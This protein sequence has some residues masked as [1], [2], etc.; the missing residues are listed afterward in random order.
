MHT[1]SSLPESYLSHELRGS[2]RVG[3]FSFYYLCFCFS[4]ECTLGT[5]TA[6]ETVL[7]EY[8][9]ARTVRKRKNVKTLD[10]CVH[11]FAYVISF[12]PKGTLLLLFP[13]PAWETGTVGGV[14]WWLWFTQLV[15]GVEPGWEPSSVNGIVPYLLLLGRDLGPGR[16]P[17]PL[18]GAEKS[19]PE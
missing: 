8:R 5:I 1:H 6:Q 15:V 13:L 18:A 16:G 12:N 19:L 11:H 10:S 17:L 4:S 7:R 14:G 3:F 2:R 9:T